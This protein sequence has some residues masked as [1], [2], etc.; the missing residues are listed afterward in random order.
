MRCYCELCWGRGCDYLDG[1]K[2][3][4]CEQCNGTGI[5]EVE[6]YTKFPNTEKLLKTFYSTS[7]PGYDCSS[8]GVY[9]EAIADRSLCFVGGDSRASRENLPIEWA[10]AVFYNILIE[11]LQD[12]GFEVSVRYLKEAVRLEIKKPLL[13][14]Y[15]SSKKTTT[16]ADVGEYFKVESSAHTEGDALLLAI[17]KIPPIKLFEGKEDEYNTY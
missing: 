15:F 2:R 6:Q 9:F 17:E 16:L 12:M 8:D 13:P 4:T 11:L 7:G 3:I 10:K 14:K 1:G 5:A